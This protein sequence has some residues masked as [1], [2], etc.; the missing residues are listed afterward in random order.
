MSGEQVVIYGD[1]ASAL[2]S[3]LRVALA[4]ETAPYAQD[5][6]VGTKVPTGDEPYAANTPL[7]VVTQ[8]APGTAQLRANTRAPIRVMV[9]HAT[10]DDA[11]DLAQLVHALLLTHSGPIVRSV[12]AGTSPWVT[13]DPDTGEPLGSFT[14]TAN[15]R[16]QLHPTA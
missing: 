11:Y 5:V 8:N 15:V 9:W 2:A 1:A 4:G 6:R 14:V 10:D 13:A 7:V 3:A 12:L 16:G